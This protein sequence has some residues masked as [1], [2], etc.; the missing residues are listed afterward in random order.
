[1]MLVFSVLLC[2]FVAL[3]HGQT[4]S[5]SGWFWVADAQERGRGLPPGVS[6]TVD[7]NGNVEYID[8]HYTTPAYQDEAFRLMILEANQAAQA[9]QLKEDL[10]ITRSRIDGARI[11]PFGF[12]Y[13]EGLM[14]YVATT[15]YSYRVLAAGKLDHIEID[16]SYEV[17]RALQDSLL[18]EDQVDNQAAY[19]LATQWL[20][21]LSVDVKALNRDCQ[22]TVASSPILNY[23]GSGK[24]PTRRMF[25][26]TYD[27]MWKS[28][29]GWPAAGVQLYL[30]DKLL[31]QLSIDD[32]RYNLRPPIVFTNLA[33]LFPGQAVIKTNYPV[34]PSV[35]VAVPPVATEVTFVT[36]S[37]QPEPV[38]HDLSLSRWIQTQTR[39]NTNHL[40]LSQ[41]MT[42]KPVSGPDE[43]GVV[44]FELPVRFNALHSDK[45]FHSGGIDLGTF[46]TNGDFIDFTLS[47]FK[48]APDG[49]SRLSWNIN[50]DSPGWHKVRARMMY[51]QGVDD[52]FTL[53]GPPLSYYSSN[54]CR[55]Y[56]GSTLLNSEGANLYAKLREPAA[57]FRVKVTSLQG[58]LVNDISGSTTNGEINLAWDLTGLDGKKYTN[59][60]FIGSFYVTYPG[61]T[62]TNAPAKARFC[63]IGTSGD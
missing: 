44:T 41:L 19:Q 5:R 20:A 61:D 54:A 10:P 34:T 23:V 13:R 28:S 24:E 11:S 12:F 7:T 49:N 48:Q 58:R 35:I 51:E 32:P 31:I 60:S 2:T 43:W 26:P 9:L 50:W 36:D 15:N 59:N 30:P 17:W 42:L 1:M 39:L 47:D 8:H 25:A 27:V 38:F 45:L 4:N 18:P 53:I 56:E 33:A 63:K 16:H 52:S 14:G 55:F 21:S 46:S 37:N 40:A 22:L 62:R 29:N 57:K 3:V 6:R